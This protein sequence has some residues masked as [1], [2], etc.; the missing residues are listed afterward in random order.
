[1]AWESA[2]NGGRLVALSHRGIDDSRSAY[3]RE[4]GE[5]RF[6]CST[7]LPNSDIFQLL[8]VFGTDRLVLQR[9]N[10]QTLNTVKMTAVVCQEGEIVL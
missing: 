1:M 10:T 6:L 9:L 4:N 5:L 7:G 3:R 2:E 8:R